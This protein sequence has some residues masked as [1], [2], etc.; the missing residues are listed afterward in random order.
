[1][2]IAGTDSGLAVT[3]ASRTAMLRP[4]EPSEFRSATMAVR[5]AT[6][7]P[8]HTATLA[9]PGGDT[10]T[11]ELVPPPARALPLSDYTGTYTSQ[12]LDVQ[13]RVASRAGKLY[14]QRRPADE[15]ELRPVYADDFQAGGG[16]GTLR[17][18]RDSSGRVSGFSF[19]AGRVLDVRFDRK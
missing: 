6:R 12:E 13:F 3:R 19:F 17:F 5:F 7:A 15:F 8:R 2:T 14:L 11:V 18:R 10:S 16:L 1:V 9:L 4:V